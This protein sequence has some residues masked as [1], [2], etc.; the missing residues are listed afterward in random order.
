M[1]G[2]IRKETGIYELPSQAIRGQEYTCPEC[3]RAVFVKQGNIRI[4]HFA[5][6]QD[7]QP[8]K[9]YDRTGGGETINHKNAKIIIKNIIETKRSFTIEK[10][11][12]SCKEIN[13][14]NFPVDK[15]KEVI[16]EAKVENGTADIMASLDDGTR[17]IIEVCHTNPTS[18]REG[19]WFE[20]STAEIQ[21]KYKSGDIVMS[22]SR[23]FRCEKCNEEIKRANELRK[24]RQAEEEKKQQEITKQR[25]I[26]IR[27]KQEIRT[28][29]KRQLANDQMKQQ[30]NIRKKE[31]AENQIVKYEFDLV[32]QDW[33]K[34]HGTRSKR[35]EIQR[36]F[37]TF[38]TYAEEN[39]IAI[40]KFKS[41]IKSL[42][43]KMMY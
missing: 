23:P 2:A 10:C 13:S 27:Q 21:E 29:L 18:H 30:V 4:H 22:C 15:V 8:C 35:Y 14:Y 32:Y 17:I 3:L 39:S 41:L 33:F 31:E 11:C 20:F 38:E 1:N 40:T 9:N 26:E 19:L 6:K 12:V 28:D 36:S 16:L 42:P 34:L 7:Q 25:E 43:H 24:I 5:H 37:K